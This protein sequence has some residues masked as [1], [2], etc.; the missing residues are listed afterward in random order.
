M[1]Y[2]IMKVSI[3]A[4][5]GLL[6]LPEG[7]RAIAVQ[8][9]FAHGDLLHIWFASDAIPEQPADEYPLEIAPRYTVY[10][11]PECPDPEY[12]KVTCE[13]EVRHHKRLVPDNIPLI[14]DWR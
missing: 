4:L 11:N 13:V 8:Q 3:E 6:H 5:A 2:G 14:P 9:D 12:R 1:G 10:I 7:Y